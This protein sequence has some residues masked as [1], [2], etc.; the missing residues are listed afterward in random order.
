MSDQ[1]TARRKRHRVEVRVSPQQDALI[2]QAADLENTTVTA[3][4]LDSVTARAEQV[5]QRHRDLMLASQ[6]FDRFIAELDR[7]AAPVPELAA[8]FQRHPKLPEA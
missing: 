7:P 6:D 5:V 4:M 2:R 1:A 3:F 8:L